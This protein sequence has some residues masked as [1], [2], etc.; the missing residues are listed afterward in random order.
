MAQ[1]GKEG[2]CYSLPRESQLSQKELA[3]DCIIN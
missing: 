2:S 1:K 3:K